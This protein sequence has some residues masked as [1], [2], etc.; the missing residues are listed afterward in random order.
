[1][2]RFRSAAFFLSA[3][4]AAGALSTTLIAWTLVLLAH[5]ENSPAGHPRAGHAYVSDQFVSVS[6]DRIFSSRPDWM[7]VDGESLRYAWQYRFETPLAP[8][9]IDVIVR[10][11]LLHGLDPTSGSQAHT[12]PVPPPWSGA[13]QPPSLQDVQQRRHVVEQASGW[14]RIAMIG[15]WEAHGSSRVEDM[16]PHAAIPLPESLAGRALPYP[17]L[18][19]L[20]AYWP[21]FLFDTAIFGSVWALLIVVVRFGHVRLILPMRRSRS[22]RQ[23]RCPS[24]RYPFGDLPRC[25]ECG[26]DLT[27]RGGKTPAA[28]PV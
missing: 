15:Y 26:D 14:P 24:C 5:P 8:D 22:L 7:R 23:G 17:A 1:M 12:G 2:V 3:C 28:G 11:P 19:P 18:L 4:I 9:G 16:T 10:S 27:P 21:G 20:K 6:W 13:G 25:P